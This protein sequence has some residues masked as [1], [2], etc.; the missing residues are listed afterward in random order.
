MR[1]SKYSNAITD[2]RIE[3]S[4]V[5]LGLVISYLPFPLEALGT[6]IMVMAFCA[7]TEKYT[8]GLIIKPISSILSQCGI[9]AREEL[10]KTLSVKPVGLQSMWD[11]FNQHRIGIAACF[12]SIYKS[13]D[14][15]D[16]L[17]EGAKIFSMLGLEYN[18]FNSVFS[19]LTGSI[20]RVLSQDT[21]ESTNQPDSIDTINLHT[22]QRPQIQEMDEITHQSLEDLIPL[23]GTAATICGAQITDIDMSGFI[24]NSAKNIQ[25]IKVIQAQ[26]KT[27]MEQSGLI[28][29]QNYTTI[30]HA[31]SEINTI[32]DEILDLKNIY[33]S[34]ASEFMRD[35]TYNRLIAVKKRAEKI[36]RELKSIE[37]NELKQHASVQQIFTLITNIHNLVHDVELVRT[38]FGS[39]VVPIGVV[40]Y[41]KSQI[42][43]STFTNILIDA[44]KKKLQQSYSDLYPDAEKWEVWNVQNRD[45]YDQGY[46]GQEI[47]VSDDAFQDKTNKDHLK[48]IQLISPTP[49]S[50]VQADLKE[51]GK[52][53]RSELVIASCNELP[54]TSLTI[55][56]IDALHNRF[57]ICIHMKLKPNKEPPKDGNFVDKPDWLNFNMESMQLYATATHGREGKAVNIRNIVD[58]ICELM[59]QKKMIYNTQVQRFNNVRLMADNEDSRIIFNNPNEESDEEDLADVIQ[60][61]EQHDEENLD[62]EIFPEEQHLLD[63]LPPDRIQRFRNA[64]RRFLTSLRTTFNDSIEE[65]RRIYI[66]VLEYTRS[67]VTLTQ[68]QLRDL[69]NSI[70]NR[71]GLPEVEQAHFNLNFPATVHA[72]ANLV[73]VSAF[74]ENLTREIKKQCRSAIRNKITSVAD[75][76]DWVPLLQTKPVRMSYPDGF[77]TDPQTGDQVRRFRYETIPSKSF[78]VWADEN[79]ENMVISRFIPCLSLFEV[80]PQHLQR[81]TEIWVRQRAVCYYDDVL[82]IDVLWGPII[83]NGEHIIPVSDR[84]RSLIQS[85]AMLPENFIVDLLRLSV[86]VSLAWCTSTVW[87]V[88][89]GYLV[90]YYSLYNFVRRNLDDTPF[91]MMSAWRDRIHRR[92]VMWIWWRSPY[93][94]TDIATD[95]L[96]H[97]PLNFLRDLH[98]QLSQY[99]CDIF[100]SLLEWLGVD[101]SDFWNQ[102]LSTTIDMAILVA[103]MALV[104]VI[105]YMLYTAWSKPKETPRKQKHIQHIQTRGHYSGNKQINKKTLTRGLK[106]A[107]KGRIQTQASESFRTFVMQKGESE[108]AD[109]DFTFVQTEEVLSEECLNKH[110]NEQKI[111]PYEA[112]QYLCLLGEQD[113]VYNTS[114][115]IFDDQ[116][117]PMTDIDENIILG[118]IHVKPHVVE[119][120]YDVTRKGVEILA[121]FTGTK[122]EIIS[123]LLEFKNIVWKKFNP[124][125]WYM[126]NFINQYEDNEFLCIT[127]IFIWNSILDGKIVGFTRKQ[128]A[129]LDRVRDEF[130]GIP[131]EP[132][133]K[134]IDVIKF[135]SDTQVLDVTSKIVKSNLVYLGAYK[136]SYVYRN[137]GLG[138]GN[139]VLTTAHTVRDCDYVRF[140]SVGET[141]DPLNLNLGFQVAVIKDIDYVRDLAILRILNLEEIK[142]LDFDLKKC[143]PNT[144]R[145][146]S[147]EPYLLREDQWLSN[148]KNAAAVVYL[149]KSKQTCPV[150]ISYEGRQQA[151]L[152][153]HAINY[154]NDDLNVKKVIDI[155]VLTI[156]EAI[157]SGLMSQIGD[158]GG[159][160]ILASG[161][162]TGKLVG[163]FNGAGEF[164]GYGAFI[165]TEDF[166]F[167]NK[168]IDNIKFYSQ[169]DHWSKLIKYGNIGNN[170][171]PGNEF[172]S[173][174]TLIEQSLPAAKTSL[175]HWKITPW[176]S[177]FEKKKAPAALSPNDSRIKIE[178][179]RNKLGM[180]SLVLDPMSK[181]GE[182]LP[183]PDMEILIKVKEDY[184]KYLQ[185]VLKDQF[186]DLSGKT[187]DELLFDG[188]N[189]TPEYEFVHGI[190]T[191]KASGLP[192]SLSGVPL[193]KDL[194]DMDENGIRTI[195]EDAW[196]RELMKRLVFRIDSAKHGQRVL[197]LTASKLKDE[198][199]K[200]EKIAQGK[201]RVFH[202]VPVEVLIT[203]SMCWQQLK[204]LFIKNSHKCFNAVGINPHSTQ[205]NDLYKFLDVHPNWLDMDYANYDKRLP[206]SFMHAAYDIIIELC[207]YD[208]N[209]TLHKLR[210]I[211]KVENID[212]FIVDY[213]TVYR[214][215]RGNKSGAYLTTIINCIINTMYSYYI[216]L[217]LTNTNW[218]EFTENTRHISYGD[219]KIE[220][221]SNKYAEIYNF[222]TIKEELIKIG[223]VA[224]PGNK[225][226][227]E[228][229]FLDI[230]EIS[231]LKRK[232]V[233]LYGKCVAPL[234]KD[235]IENPFIWTQTLPCK[236]DIWKNLI[237]EQLFEVYLHGKEYYDEF[238]EKLSQ[239]EHKVLWEQLHN[240]TIK[241]YD[242][243]G[244]EYDQ[245]YHGF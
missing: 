188:L 48:W 148:C 72:M 215:N 36:E 232:F 75:L 79:A 119:N 41:G 116:S 102:I 53:Y 220:T 200:L 12:R 82:G 152:Q 190:D 161:K 130:N 162:H 153:S 133:E 40:L 37:K 112:S 198:C 98:R 151:L 149:P 97:V 120:N 54:S 10:I 39:R 84:T 19:S 68:N 150:N 242:D 221:V 103:I 118:C 140:K 67:T 18:I 25:A 207:K 229:A 158:C 74:Q 146:S 5:L 233:L 69:L 50:T 115:C 185:G 109:E 65:T 178:L 165:T 100:I 55:K 33:T 106:L 24:Q 90:A 108:D 228:S 231:F 42:G 168:S 171:P 211:S 73:T 194:I 29:S 89:T 113:T 8:S 236:V 96:F 137:Y 160:I 192:W 181:M 20:A 145:F 139:C 107:R 202:C 88:G 13:K 16:L 21:L 9:K 164:H 163:M 26:V 141:N 223:Q 203:D 230:K 3:L 56:S 204:N 166:Y 2:N 91:L 216:W 52:P 226:D 238:I 35:E 245:R 128:L 186:I 81:F 30:I 83:E 179:P 195:K 57:P 32:R 210:I 143:C 174:G 61:G 182:T 131:D 110:I 142:T 101:V 85:S 104:V 63:G 208:K 6:T 23:V 125:T 94:L 60:H 183:E 126:L 34:R 241:S 217:K 187:D 172:T 27:A 4:F 206:R 219:D 64:R 31:I 15:E 44:V 170:L 122:K 78:Q 175:S 46:Y 234:V 86:G 225:G 58:R 222:H 205:W 227:K 147:I 66:E 121:Q 243:I 45:D 111:I 155:D 132:K 11:H 17:A 193:K 184:L 212:T 189:G 196:G 70:R 177:Q 99:C 159:P 49:V 244:R 80:A 51:K 176:T 87:I 93:L 28:K 201:T 157:I 197:S 138:S 62:D 199:V 38:N 114:T 169:N 105:L 218:V 135:S 214:T 136:K 7:I 127:N 71:R 191:S 22:E 43:K 14:A 59:S 47:T 154:V 224:T 117:Q 239:C 156:S 76:G 124:S 123:Q 167:D 235:S 213:D 95:L 1:I 237:T 240:C 209:D 129:H 144:K 77:T 134:I 92:D 173:I 180:P